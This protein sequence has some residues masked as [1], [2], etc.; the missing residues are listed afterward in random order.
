LDNFSILNSLTPREVYEVAREE[1]VKMSNLELPKGRL[2]PKKSA[3]IK[4]INEKRGYDPNHFLTEEFNAKIFARLVNYS[5]ITNEYDEI[6]KYSKSLS[7]RIKRTKNDTDGLSV[8]RE[9]VRFLRGFQEAL[10]FKYAPDEWSYPKLD[11]KGNKTYRTGYKPGIIFPHN[12]GYSVAFPKM[13]KRATI[14]GAREVSPE[15]AEAMTM[16]IDNLDEVNRVLDEKR[17]KQKD[18]ADQLDD[19][20][21]K[22]EIS[23][24]LERKKPKQ[25]FENVSGNPL[26]FM[27]N[28][29]D[30]SRYSDDAL[31]YIY[32]ESEKLIQSG[33]SDDIAHAK[34]KAEIM[35]RKT[36]NPSGKGWNDKLQKKLLRKK[37]DV[38]MDK[39]KKTNW[40][41]SPSGRLRNFKSMNNKKFDGIYALRN[42]Y[43][44]DKEAYDAVMAEAKKRYTSA[45]RIAETDLIFESKRAASKSRQTENR[46]D[47]KIMKA[48]R[49]DK[50]KR[51]QVDQGRVN[52]DEYVISEKLDGFRAI[53]D[54]KEFRSKNGNVFFAPESFK[55]SMPKGVILDGELWMGREKYKEVSQVLRRQ[56]WDSKEAQEEAW[57]KF[58]FMVFDSPSM[59]TEKKSDGFEDWRRQFEKKYMTND[60]GEFAIDEKNW[61]S[62][63]A[64][65]V[66]VGIIGE[67]VDD[68]YDGMVWTPEIQQIRSKIAL[69]PQI[70]VTEVNMHTTQKDLDAIQRYAKKLGVRDSEDWYW[71][72]ETLTLSDE[73]TKI[74][75]AELIEQGIIENK[76]NKM[77]DDVLIEMTDLESEGFMLRRKDSA[78]EPTN[79]SGTRRSNSILKVK[80]RFTEEALVVGYEEGLG[81]NENKVGSLLMQG[82][83]KGVKRKWKLGA[84]LDDKNRENPPP[85]GSVIEYAWTGRTSTGLPKEASFLRARPDLD[86]KLYARSLRRINGERFT[87]LGILKDKKYARNLSSV[88]RNNTQRKIR[89]IPKSGGFS[90][91]VGP[92]R[93]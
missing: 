47:L 87:E 84:G 50:T 9:G 57:D 5:A 61:K 6:N 62:S 65:D 14:K 52:P 80:P 75:R 33:D 8:Y 42:D 25:I 58:T 51:K 60:Q 13:A 53:W 63:V 15:A 64:K 30:F 89:I 85:K 86:P 41:R 40:A 88:I 12:R 55:S 19:W 34:L 59:N 66:M 70:D 26:R 43:K 27:G 74:S 93:K 21:R 2:I 11:K 79:E 82:T 78:F 77:I 39:D 4:A 90:L 49:F 46:S 1:N 56:N 24:A 22:R 45:E 76:F 32:Q 54:G 35:K 3:L 16:L 91:Y 81:R 37:G 38:K 83:Y 92:R 7:R 36:F 29:R 69:V 67:P 48:K 44:D 71:D 10:G 68:T 72:G 28:S 31:R 73:D 17:A 18:Y 20:Q 23:Q